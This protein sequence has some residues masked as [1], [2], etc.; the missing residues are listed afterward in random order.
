MKVEE[1]GLEDESL[2]GKDEGRVESRMAWG[3]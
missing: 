1:T 3:F 2:M